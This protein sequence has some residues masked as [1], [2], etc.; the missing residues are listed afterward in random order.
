MTRLGTQLAGAL[1]TLLVMSFVVFCLMGLMPGDPI[2]LMLA[3]NPQMTPEDAA[4]LRALYGLDQ[5]LPVRWLHWLGG[6][7][8]GET[9]YSRLYGL[10]VFDVLLPR[11][12][13]T[14]LL[15]G[16]SLLVTIMFALPLAVY[17][18][19][20]PD[21]P[22]SRALNIF[23][24]AGIAAPPFWCAL[25]LIAFFAVTLGWLPASASLEK[26]LSFILPVATMTLASL[27]VYLRHLMSAMGEALHMPHIR[28][29]EA[30]GCNKDRVL[31]HHAFPLAATPLITLLALDLGTLFGGALTIETIFAYPGMGKLLFDAVMG[32]DYNLAL[33][34]FLLLT[35]CVLTANIIADVLYGLIDPRVK[36]DAKN[37]AA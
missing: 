29:A 14:A 35:A 11:L 19:S 31:W 9:G 25:L 12:G 15:M 36:I 4:R 34:G 27:A 1:V 30:K 22:R 18:S 26:P 17:T 21:S 6:L 5:P 7:I 28:T 2:D 20:R 8:T 33:I 16:L 32:S 23:C 13:N 3:G 37:G 10:P 24:L